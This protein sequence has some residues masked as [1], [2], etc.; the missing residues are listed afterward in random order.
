[1]LNGVTIDTPILAPM[2]SVVNC[3]VR[4]REIDPTRLQ[5][6]KPKSVLT[7]ARVMYPGPNRSPS[8]AIATAAALAT[9]APWVVASVIRASATRPP[10]RLMAAYVRAVRATTAAMSMALIRSDRW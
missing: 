3:E 1:M 9:P 8:Q 5:V 2:I 10:P 4:S 6:P 7:P